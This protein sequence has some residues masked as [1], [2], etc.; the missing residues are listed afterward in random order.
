MISTYWGKTD[1]GAKKEL[2]W[3]LQFREGMGYFAIASRDF[4]AGE[5]ICREKATTYTAGWHPFN[6]AQT[7]RINEDVAKLSDEEQRGFFDMANVF[8]ECDQAAGIYMTNSFEIASSSSSTTTG[9]CGMYLAI[10]RL[11]HSCRP[12]AQQTHIPSTKEEVSY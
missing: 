12:N 2:P 4:A 3:E 5:L 6:E 11:N 7:K 1:F 10:A 9:S 8:P